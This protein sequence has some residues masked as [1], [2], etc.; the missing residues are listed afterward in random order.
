MPWWEIVAGRVRLLM[1]PWATPPE[2][3]KTLTAWR[4][5]ATRLC[6]CRAPWQRADAHV[7]NGRG[8]WG[9]EC[10]RVDDRVAAA[11]TKQHR[12]SFAWH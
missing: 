5:H 2:E 3:L 7:A 12:D 8:R 4:R 9:D 6:L 11:V 1:R 10:G